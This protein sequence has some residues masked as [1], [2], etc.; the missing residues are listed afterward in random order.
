MR[1][2]ATIVGAVF[3]ISACG[4]SDS[5]KTERTEEGDRVRLAK[6]RQEVE[7]AIGEAACGSIEDCRYA[8]LG[9]KPCGGPWEYIVYSVADSTA[10]AK[11][12]AAYNG[13]EAGMNQR[14]SYSS[15]CS[16]PNEPMLVCSAG[17]CIDLLR[18]ETVSIGKGPADEPRV[19]HPALPRFAMDMTATSDEFALRET[20]I[21]GDILTLIV[22]YGGGCEAHEFE[23]IASLAATKSI[24]PQHVLKLLHDGNGDVCEAYLTSELRF[25]LMPFR[26][27]YPGM[28]GVAFRLQGVEDLLQ[29]AF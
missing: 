25:D 17:R 8:G 22:G 5:V 24:P 23:L 18:G 16:V 26:G 10:L 15:D 27:L 6:M 11:Q 2:L 14:Y 4:G 28:D 29:Y 3:L 13:F 9:S 12:L 21:E 7:E 20:R 1:C 19:A